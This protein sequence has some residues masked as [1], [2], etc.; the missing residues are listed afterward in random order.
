MVDAISCRPQTPHIR[1]LCLFTT[2]RV[3]VGHLYHG[4]FGTK[5]RLEATRSLYI[6]TT[7]VSNPPSASKRANFANHAFEVPTGLPPR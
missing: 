7:G 1:G 5:S 6:I 2:K 4:F 3:E